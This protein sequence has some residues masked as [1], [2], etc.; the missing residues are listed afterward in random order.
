[1]RFKLIDLFGGR[2]HG[3]VVTDPQTR[4]RVEQ[5]TG[6][7]GDHLGGDGHFT[8]SAQF[9]WPV[10]S[11]F[12]SVVPTN[13]ATLLGFGTWVAF[14]QGRVLVGIDPTDPDWDTVLET[15]GEKLHILTCDEIPTCP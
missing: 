13:P 14:A 10:G 12:I 5:F 8:P 3:V 7:P 15:R 2:R 9:G 4:Q 6:N 1:M 11:V